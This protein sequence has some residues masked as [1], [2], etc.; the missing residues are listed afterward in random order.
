MYESTQNMYNED[1][2]LPYAKTLPGEP[3]GKELPCLYQ[4][5]ANPKDPPLEGTFQ[6]YLES[7]YGIFTTSKGVSL[8]VAVKDLTF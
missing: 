6:A 3:A 2:G 7:S 8:T 1:I 4:A 5:S